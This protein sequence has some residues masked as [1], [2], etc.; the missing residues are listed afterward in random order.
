MTK[1]LGVHTVD[2]H[3]GRTHDDDNG[4]AVLIV[5]RD[6]D[7]RALWFSREVT[8][9]VLQAACDDWLASYTAQAAG[10]PTLPS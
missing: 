3:V 9:D 10:E 8:T 1:Q 5:G 4:Y 6:V 7:W 2:I